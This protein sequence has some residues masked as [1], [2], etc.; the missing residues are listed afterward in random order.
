MTHDD[1]I[2]LALGL[3]GD[4][5]HKHELQSVAIRAMPK[6]PPANLDGVLAVAY[7]LGDPTTPADHYHYAQALMRVALWI[8]ERARAERATEA[9]VRAH[10]MTAFDCAHP[11]CTQTDGQPCAFA[12]CPNKAVAA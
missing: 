4:A 2:A 10:Q 1:D 6:P 8:A 9:L 11:G 12:E 7:G 3:I 5:V